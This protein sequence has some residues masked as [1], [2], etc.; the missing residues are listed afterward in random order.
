MTTVIGWM[1]LANK[2]SVCGLPL[3]WTVKSSRVEVGHQPSLRVGHRRVDGDDR[4]AALEG[5]LGR[6]SQRPALPRLAQRGE[7]R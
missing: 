3:S 4:S 2:V 6:R 7:R 5:W 1:S